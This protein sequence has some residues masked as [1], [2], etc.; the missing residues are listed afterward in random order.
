M[1]E[2]HKPYVFVTLQGPDDGGDFGPNTPGTRTSGFQEAF[3]YAHEH[4]RDVYVWGGR[5][6]MHDGKGVSG[7]VYT[8][9]E[10][11]RIPW[12]QDWVIGGGNYLLGYRGTTG[13]AIHIDSLMNCRIKLGLLT[14]ASKDGC[15]VRIKPTTPGPDD[16]TVI[17]ASVIE[18]SA[19]CSMGTGIVIDS[20]DGIIVNSR[21]FAEETNTRDVGV[22]LT[23][24]GGKGFPIANN[25]I[26]VMFGNQMHADD[27]S[28]G[29]RV[30]DPGTSKIFNN[31]IEG[32][33]H[34][35]RGAYLDEATGKYLTP[36]EYVPEHAIGASIYA[37]RN[38]FHSSFY[39]TRGPGHDI[40]FEADAR[41]N[42]VYADNLPN[43]V[44]NTAVHPTNRVVPNWPVGF[45]LPTPDVPGSGQTL[46][47]R[48]PYTAQII[49]L[50]PGDVASWTLTDS[51]STPQKLSRNLSLADNLNRRDW[52]RPDDRPSTSVTIPAGLTSGQTITLEP[53]DA[54]ELDYSKAPTW[55]WK[56]LR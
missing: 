19:V 56:A 18:F 30:G 11:L 34:A 47:N 16:F 37:Q 45:D 49:V 31:R 51:G 36:E 42:T 28:T 21:I 25:Q 15:T 54:L 17:T 7:N 27:N 3:D 55:T 50:D 22:Y 5:G 20:S 23:D 4:C 26:T 44:T 52:T 48:N 39:G 13:D 10:T 32:S 35:P 9:D 12:S 24:N 33:Y 43:G 29:I 8:L 2:T 41:D 6:G 46:V 38:E 1:A 53:G 40:V 14:S